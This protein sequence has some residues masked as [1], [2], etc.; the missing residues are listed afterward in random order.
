[1]EK[2]IQALEDYRLANSQVA[3]RIALP[4][5]LSGVHYADS[6]ELMTVDVGALIDHLRSQK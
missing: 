3:G 1:M 4:L 5:P 2:I 6:L